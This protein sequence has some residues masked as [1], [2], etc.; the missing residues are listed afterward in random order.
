[1]KEFYIIEN[2]PNE[3]Y[4]LTKHN[5]LSNFVSESEGLIVYEDHGLY[6]YKD[7]CGTVVIS[8]TYEDAKNFKN[9]LAFTKFKNKWGAI[10]R[11]DQ[12]LVA[13]E[14]DD[15]N[16]WYNDILQVT[17]GTLNGL[18]RIQDERILEPKYYSISRPSNGL[19][20]AE[21]YTQ[22]LQK[23][24]VNSKGKIIA[25]SKYIWTVLLQDLAICV[26]RETSA[27]LYDTHGSIVEKFDT[28]I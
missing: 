23:G 21:I 6:G 3:G 18:V 11:L 2:K 28:K 25:E 5:D 7:A 26:H 14:H 17:S 24:V 8:P 22:D 4:I 15:I 9:G 16:W 20:W 27:D 10:N 13:H 1:M 12:P 19:D